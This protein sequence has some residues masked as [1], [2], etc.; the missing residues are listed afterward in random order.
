MSDCIL[1]V[2]RTED[3][4]LIRVEGKGTSQDSPALAAFV[5]QY[6]QSEQEPRIT[7]DLSDC[8]Y[9]DSTFLGCLLTLHRQCQDQSPAS[10]TVIADQ[11]QRAKLLFP[12]RVDSV[13]QISEA[14]P[15]A[16]SSFLRL[17]PTELDKRA[18]GWHVLETHRALASVKGP[19]SQLFEQIANS[20]S[21]ELEDPGECADDGSQ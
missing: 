17:D 8:E 9:L 15:Q 21:R 2:A 19:G 18:Y 3:G 6:L 12:T 14:A 10:L 11:E 1:N 7:V 4:Y 5:R 16:V 13:L 20:L